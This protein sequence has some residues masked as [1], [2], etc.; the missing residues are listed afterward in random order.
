MIQWTSRSCTTN[1]STY[2]R[3]CFPR[4][5]APSLGSCGGPDW[6]PRRRPGSRTGCA[7]ECPARPA[8]PGDSRRWV[9]RSGPSPRPPSTPARSA[10][11]ATGRCRPSVGGSGAPPGDRR[12]AVRCLAEWHRLGAA[13]PWRPHSRHH[14]P[15]SG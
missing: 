1:G 2:R 3:S 12:A 8:A 9:Q 4:G 11:A 15:H 13:A 10:R 14:R 6:W 7:A 5:A